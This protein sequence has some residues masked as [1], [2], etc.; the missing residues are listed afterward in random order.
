M[1]IIF[2][3]IDGVLN[4]IGQGRDQFGSIFHKH[5]EDNLR[6]LIEQTGAKI[7]IS[8]SWRFSGLDIMKDMWLKR[9]LP[10]EVIDI[11]PYCAMIHEDE[12]YESYESVERGYEIQEWLNKHPEVENYVILDD[13][14]MLDSQLNN[15]V[16]TSEN[17]H[18][19]E[20]NHNH[21]NDFVQFV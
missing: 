8:S 12:S 9:N 2:L 20:D 7:V 21:L 17:S 11:T 6:Y 14:D 10:G 4:V 18:C 15:F 5:F 16:K 1:K 19:N 3:D 13:D